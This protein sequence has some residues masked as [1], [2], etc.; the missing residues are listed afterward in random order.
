MQLMLF[1]SIAHATDCSSLLCKKPSV[2][3]VK[4]MY[5]TKKPSVGTVKKMYGT[6]ASLWKLFYY[7]PKK[8]EALK[9][10]QSVLNLPELKVVKPSETRWLSHER[11]VRAILQELPALIIALH[12]LYEDCGDAEAYGIALVL[13]SYSWPL[14][15]F[16]HQCLIFLPDSIKEGN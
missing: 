3:T 14:S 2:G 9:I 1:A 16:Y 4:K 11:C 12:K 8:A 13:S 5:G 7:S 6:M 10:V 15:Y